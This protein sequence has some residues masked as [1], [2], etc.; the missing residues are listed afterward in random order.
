[1]RWQSS[2]I[3]TETSSRNV[4]ILFLLMHNRESQ[5]KFN[6]IL[7][8]YTNGVGNPSR[9]NSSVRPVT[10][11]IVAM[12]VVV[13]AMAVV[14]VVVVEIYMTRLFSYVQMQNDHHTYLL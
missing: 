9:H 14:V 2:H 4:L 13:V 1:M 5:Q 11:V 7:T 6:Y 3:K 12:D 10:I 8:I